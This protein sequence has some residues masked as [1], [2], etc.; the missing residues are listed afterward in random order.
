[1]ITLE[2]GSGGI[3][4]VNSSGTFTSSSAFFI[5]NAGGDVNVGGGTLNV[6]STL[7]HSGTLDLTSGTVNLGVNNHVVHAGSATNI[8]GG[9]MNLNGN[10]TVNGIVTST[11]AG[12]FTQSNGTTLTVQNAGSV[13]VG[14]TGIGSGAVINVNGPA[15]QY[16]ATSFTLNSGSTVNLNGGAMQFVAGFNPNGGLSI[17]TRAR[18]AS[19]HATLNGTVLTAL[20][21]SSQTLG[22]AKHLEVQG[23]ASLQSPLTL[24]GGTFSVG[25]L[26]GGNLLT[27]NSGT[28]N[29]TNSG[30][31]IGSGGA[32][33]AVVHVAPGMTIN[34]TSVSGNMVGSDGRLVLSGGTFN[35]AAS[36]TNNGEV[37]LASP[38]TTLGGSFGQSFLILDKQSAGPINGFFAGL[39]E[40]SQ[41]FVNGFEYTISYQG[42]DGNDIVLSAV[43]EPGTWALLGLGLAGAGG[44]W[45]RRRQE[46]IVDDHLRAQS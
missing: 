24:A 5:V 45:Y 3:L 12:A 14:N 16:A 40:G 42:G 28:L 22:A 44:W 9:T 43:P 36:L 38:L 25:D 34:Q 7:S 1:P 32:P 29:V 30:L 17:S 39:P 18:C 13:S 31:T 15:A 46:R 19:P 20:L 2:L 21:G 6:N 8:T 41:L 26:S 10:L 11:G 27:F 37:Q 4:N 33:G 23:S 35:T